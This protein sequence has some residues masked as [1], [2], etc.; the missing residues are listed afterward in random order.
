MY[1]VALVVGSM[2]QLG[3]LVDCRLRAV[4]ATG[5]AL[6]G[7]PRKGRPA[8]LAAYPFPRA[9]REKG[10]VTQSLRGLPLAT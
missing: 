10:E 6:A 3:Y 4:A 8:A 5:A 1:T 7:P 9:A 2:V